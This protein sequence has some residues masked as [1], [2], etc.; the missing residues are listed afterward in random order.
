MPRPSSSHEDAARRPPHCAA[1]PPLQSLLPLISGILLYRTD[2]HA[3]IVAGMLLAFSLPFLP[4]PGQ[5]K[6]IIIGT[7]LLAGLALQAIQSPAP[8][9]TWENRPPREVRMTLQINELFTARKPGRVAG[10][11]TILQTDLPVDTV[12]DRPVAFYLESG[13]FRPLRGQRIT[14][15]A[16][17]TYLPQ[18]GEPDDYQMYLK[19]RDI[20][21]S[22][23]QG[24]ITG[25]L[26]PAPRVEQLRQRLFDASQELLTS[27]CRDPADPGNVLASML[28]GNRSLLSDERI[29]LYRRTG[30]YHL[31]AVSGLHVGSVFL[32][33]FLLVR[34]LPLPALVCLLIPLLG[35]WGY[36]WLTGGSTSAVRA[37]IMISCL[38]ISRLVFRQPHL[39]PAL[40]FSAWIVLIIDPGELFQ[41]GFQ[42]SYGVVLSIILVGLPMARHLRQFM[43][44]EAARR[45]MPSKARDRFIKFINAVNDVACVSISA[46]LASAPLIIQHFNLFT[47]GGILFG[48]L[49]N[50]LVTLSV[51]AGCLCLL[52]GPVAGTLVAGTMAVLSW[53]CIRAIEWLLA[54]CLS[55]PGAVGERE[56]LWP[57]MGTSLLAGMLGLAWSLQW[58]R[59]QGYLRNSFLYLLPHILVLLVLANGTIRT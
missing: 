6:R 13:K 50:P 20:Y 14:C 57:S 9:A 53:P 15:R 12:H 46:G 33:L 16:V 19:S 35:T 39:F 31:F 22:A 59:M 4:G 2:A 52:T 25:S 11:G 40:V 42:L 23:K 10:I 48:I 8:N 47:P 36:I 32:C 45:W 41:L 34:R 5:N 51:M 1:A 54:V 43:E 26:S 18:V 3:L 27:G 44:K 30:T 7:S 56:W 28:L 24:H 58:M 49:L 38:G 55:I 17:L 21:L 37:G 29:A